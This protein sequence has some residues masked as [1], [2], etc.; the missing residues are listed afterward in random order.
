MEYRERP[1]RQVKMEF[2]EVQ[3]CP[4][5]LEVKFSPHHFL[6]IAIIDYHI[7]KLYLVSKRDTK[8][9]YQ[10]LLEIY[11]KYICQ[12]EIQNLFFDALIFF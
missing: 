12:M 8:N 1:D 9:L 2:P 11:Q 6:L 5:C 4:E 7:V 10:L 3:E